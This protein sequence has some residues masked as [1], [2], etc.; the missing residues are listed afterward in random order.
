MEVT[1]LS[2]KFQITLPKRVREDLNAKA[3]DRIIFIKEGE[4]WVLMKLPADPVEA[5]KYLGKRAKLGGDA[6]Q[7]HEEMEG[8]EK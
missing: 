8:W 4:R 2:S 1:K 6:V 5:L 7:V 3:G